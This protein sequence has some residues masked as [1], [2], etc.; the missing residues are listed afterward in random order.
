M[1]KLLTIIRREYKENVYKKGFIIST[2]LTPIILM[3]F[4]FAP[5]LLSRVEVE[6]QKLFDV[7][8]QTGIVFEEL[9]QDL[10]TRL[11]DSTRKFV[12]KQVQGYQNWES[13]REELKLKVSIEETDG[14]IVVPAGALAESEPIE[15]YARNTG[16]F[17]MN[18]Q[19]RSAINNIITG[20]R[21]RQSGLEPDMVN[22]LTR[23]IDLKTIKITKSSEE[24]EGG[25]LQDYLSTFAMVMILY[26]TILLYGTAIMRGVLQE[27]NSRIIEIL[28]S[29]ASSFQLMMGKILGIGAAGLTQYIVWVIFGLVITSFGNLIP[30]IDS[31]VVS[32]SGSVL[33]YFVIYFILGYFIFATLYAVIGAL[34]NSDQEAQQLSF[35]IVF[36]LIIP[37]I[38]MT[39][40]VKNPDSTLSVVLSLIPFFSPI[41]MFARI[42]ISMPPAAEIILSII[43]MVLTIVIL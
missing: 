26:M 34:T 14:F 22:K 11:P 12:F 32:L 36:M 41:L 31:P 8:D 3:S 6:K 1:H 2:I 10:D 43:L 24:K 38:M 27:K 9:T 13:T 7:V 16:N 19:I 20:Y 15:L 37:L 25:F 28:L 39:F 35:P 18:R 30:G 42:N 4:I 23:W 21:I 33:V 5:A 17:D 40:M 29:S